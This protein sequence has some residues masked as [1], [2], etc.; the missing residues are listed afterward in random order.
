MEVDGIHYVCVGSAGAPWKF[1]TEETGYGRYSPESGYT[2][3]EVGAD[4]TKVSFVKP[5]VTGTEG[6]V[7]TSFTMK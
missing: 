6:T 4:S 5:D 7:V 3:V 1:G 2:F